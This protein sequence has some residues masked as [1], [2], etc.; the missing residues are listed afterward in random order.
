[1]WLL[2]NANLVPNE[3]KE[4]AGMVHAAL[5]LP[6]DSARHIY[7]RHLKR[8]GVALWGS[9][10]SKGLFHPETIKAFEAASRSLTIHLNKPGIDPNVRIMKME[11]DNFLLHFRKV[12]EIEKKQ[13]AAAMQRAR[14]KKKDKKKTTRRPRKRKY[15]G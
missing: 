15:P 5:E 6:G 9:I 8:E 10:E 3:L 2:L 14:P 7:Q 4:H 1:M 12:Q 11:I 13:K